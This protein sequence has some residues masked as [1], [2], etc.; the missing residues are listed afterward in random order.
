MSSRRPSLTGTLLAI[1][2]LALLVWQVRLVGLDHIG[3]GFKAVG[4]RGFLAILG[5]SLFRFAARSMA[6]ITLIGRPVPL[7]SATAATISGDAL[8][9]LSFLSL[10]VSEPAKAFYVTRHAPAAE[11]FAALTAENFFYSVSVASV[12]L[13]GTITLLATF[14]VP[15]SLRVAL[16]F[17]LAVMAGVL[18]AAV[19]LARSRPALAAVARSA[20]TALARRF[21]SRAPGPRVAGWLDQLERVETRT[22]SALSASPWRLGVVIACEAAFHLA[23]IAEAWLTLWFLSRAGGLGTGSATLLNAFLLDTVNRFINVAFRAVPLRVGVDEVTTSG[24]TE[25]LGL[26]S[27]AG[28]TLALVRKARMLVWAGVGLGLLGRRAIRRI[29]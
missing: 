18:A 24:F 21:L 13:G 8:G 26:G 15:D 3:D 19:W 2:G 28:L 4:W 6:W 11:A 29:L 14:V 17:S 12:I 22:Y 20:S 27:A 23:S 1:V 25:M 10:L 16:W 7:S 5:L 9:N